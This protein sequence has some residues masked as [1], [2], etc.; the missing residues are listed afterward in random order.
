MMASSGR[1]TQTLRKSRAMG[2]SV[3]NLL[4]QYKLDPTQITSS[5]PHQTLL[6]CDVLTFLNE[7]SSSIKPNTSNRTGN[8]SAP[9]TEN[10]SS[11]LS[12]PKPTVHRSSHDQAGTHLRGKY[13][14]Q[15][16][17]QLEID[18]INSGGLIEAPAQ[19]NN[20]GKQK[21]R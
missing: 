13:A 19:E 5:G 17:S 4:H 9:P 3:R 10:W 15:Q 6:K 14:R 11:F 18:V 16:P 21:R 7:R 2:P 1:L 8:Q 20:S 12:A